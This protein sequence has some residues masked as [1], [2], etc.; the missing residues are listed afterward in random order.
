M[1]NLDDALA[2]IDRSLSRKRAMASVSQAFPRVKVDEAERKIAKLLAKIDSQLGGVR[3]DAAEFKEND[4]PRGPDGKFTSGAG[5]SGK[6]SPGVVSYRQT[7]GKKIKGTSRGLIRHMLT[8]GGYSEEEILQAARDEYGPMDETH[9][10]IG[11]NL[12][13]LNEERAKAG[14]KELTRPPVKVQRDPGIR[15]YVRKGPVHNSDRLS[16]IMD[17]QKRTKSESDWHIRT[18]VWA[19]ASEDFLDVIAGTAQLGGGVISRPDLEKF[20]CYYH[21]E[22]SLIQMACSFTD[23]DSAIVF[24]HEYGHA[25]DFKSGSTQKSAKYVAERDEDAASILGSAWTPDNGEWDVEKRLE[26][27]D[28]VMN[29]IDYSKGTTQA[30]SKSPRGY[31]PKAFFHDFV[32]ALTCNV[33]GQGHTDE[34]YKGNP[35]A[36]LAEMFANYV[37]LTQGKDGDYWAGILHKIAPKSCS[38][39]DEMLEGTAE[40]G[41]V[42]MKKD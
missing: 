2:R 29:Q 11:E 4:H 13:Q 8:E 35:D 25:I 21:T 20:L 37:T 6:T 39:F 40:W 31:T 12:K 15:K 19:D 26:F 1:I 36:R 27:N 3:S 23:P 16:E 5:S 42:T 10:Y 41:R 22:S 28:R 38:R 33:L 9:D 14:K 34:Y 24:R 17:F 7:L 32:G 30:V 18:A